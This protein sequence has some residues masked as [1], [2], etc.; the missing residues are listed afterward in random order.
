MST[1]ASQLRLMSSDGHVPP[2]AGR[3]PRAWQAMRSGGIL[4]VLGDSSKYIGD[5]SG[6]GSSV[7]K[8]SYVAGTAAD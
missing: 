5:P 1:G 2:W 4:A 8:A 6:L 3:T 7:E